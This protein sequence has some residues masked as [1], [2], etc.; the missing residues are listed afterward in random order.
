MASKRQKKSGFLLPDNLTGDGSLCVQFRIPNAAEY[1]QAVKGHIYELAKWWSWER[2]FQTG[3]TRATEAATIFRTYILET[4]TFS[5]EC[6]EMSFL[7]R[8]SAENPCILEQS[9]DGGLNWTFA[10]DYSLCG[11]DNVSYEEYQ[12]RQDTE[13]ARRLSLYDGTPDSIHEDTPTT[14]FEAGGGGMTALC[15]AIDAYVRRQIHDTQWRYRVAAGL[16]AAGVGLLAMTGILGVVVG[17]VVAF[18]VGLALADVENAANDENAIKEV[19]CALKDEFDGLAVTEANFVAAITALSSAVHNEQTIIAILQGNMGATVNYL[20]FLE[21]LGEAQGAA[22][23]GV[24]SCPCDDTWCYTFNFE[25]SGIEDWV[26]NNLGYTMNYVPA[27]GIQ[28][29]DCVDTLSNPDIGYRGV[30]IRLDHASR[31]LTRLSITYD[32]TKGSFDQNT[33]TLQVRV[34]GVVVIQVQNTAETNGQHTREWIGSLA[35]DNVTVFDRASRDSSAPY[36]YSGAVVIRSVTL[37]GVGINPF[38]EDNC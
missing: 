37:E 13:N 28:H 16:A 19:V 38:G 5:E 31:T 1:V 4:L 6:G 11:A 2:S 36:S 9:V 26:D 34:G 27:L 20:M 8:Q 21:M 15:A 30:S 12:Q 3:D 29:R 17:G 33:P 24:V 35:S 23:A 10:F 7:L 25:T 22:I 32:V 14:T 18:I